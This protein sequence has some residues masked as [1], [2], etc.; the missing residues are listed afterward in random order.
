LINTFEFIETTS[1]CRLADNKSDLFQNKN[2]YLPIFECE[3]ETLVDEKD[4]LNLINPESNNLF[5]DTP[6]SNS[7]FKIKDL[8]FG[9][10]IGGALLAH[11]SKVV[12][13]DSS[14]LILVAPNL[15]LVEGYGNRRW[16]DYQL[17]TW[18]NFHNYPLCTIS[19]E[20]LP[21]LKER[22]KIYS[23]KSKVQTIPLAAIYLS[24]RSHDSNIYHWLIET[25]VRLKCLDEIPELKKL[26]LI[27]REPLNDF[28]RETL[29]IMGIENK[30]IITNGESFVID[31]LFFPS[32]PSTPAQHRKAMC[33]LREKFLSR[34]S[35]ATKPK[36]RLYIS[37]IDSNRQV[38]NEYQ[39]FE[40][41]E[42]FGYEKLVMSELSVKDQIDYFRS[43]ES[44]V[45]AHGAAG[46]HILFAPLSC[47]VIELHS[48][49]WVNHCYFS[50]CH[51]LGISYKWIIGTQ[52][53][54]SFNYLIDVNVLKAL[55]LHEAPSG[56]EK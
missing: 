49:R 2:T 48:P 19:T 52:V 1:W 12:I 44:I 25:L 31:D 42:K 4:L 28:Q 39:I 34:L 15:S 22:V 26:P 50:L 18:P 32:I 30:L 54:D 11:L 40:F 21:V 53:E 9:V 47:K 6:S 5:F 36:R 35:Q 56:N 16:A 23:I 33:W 38:A 24:V 45:I 37:R 41:L 29:E 27:V 55:V 43:A 46:A 8:I 3:D 17:N 10:E 20:N 14:L 51:I 13:K 7:G